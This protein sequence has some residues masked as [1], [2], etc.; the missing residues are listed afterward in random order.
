MRAPYISGILEY[1][2]TLQKCRVLETLEFLVGHGGQIAR[3]RS[4]IVK[5]KVSGAL[6]KIIGFINLEPTPALQFLSLTWKSDPEVADLQEFHSLAIS[7]DVTDDT[8][9]LDF[10]PRRHQLQSVELDGLPRHFV[11]MRSSPLVSNLTYLRLGSSAFL[12]SIKN[13]ST[14]LSASPRLESLHLDIT[15]TSK[16]RSE[17]VSAPLQVSL[18]LLRS[19]SLRATIFNDWC[20]SLVQ[21][22]DAPAVGH[23]KLQGDI[24]SSSSLDAS[25]CFIQFLATGRMNGV[26][27]CATVFGDLA[28]R[29]PIFQSLNHLELGLQFDSIQQPIVLQMLRA[30][31]TITQLTLQNSILLVLSEWP[32]LCSNV[33]HFRYYGFKSAVLPG[34]MKRFAFDRERYG[35]R[36]S[37]LE[38][39]FIEQPASHRSDDEETEPDYPVLLGGLV[40]KLDIKD[41]ETSYDHDIDDDLSLNDEETSDEEEEY[42]SDEEEHISDEEEYTSDEEEYTSD[43]E[44]DDIGTSE[45]SVSTDDDAPAR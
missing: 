31:T 2:D 23:F 36:I 43:E 8:H 39:F 5:A 18:P 25:S 19:F 24:G 14:L 3:W 15:R 40:D 10:G 26:L 33:S 13:T 11:F 9:A 35:M 42:I 29:G 17:A 21:I 30:Y 1:D 4:L 34:R 20:T 32:T 37:V 22:I 45:E 44:E 12:P 28:H 6:F 41:E 16:N 7:R 27:Q 38:I